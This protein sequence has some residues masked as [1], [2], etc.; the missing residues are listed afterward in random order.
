MPTFKRLISLLHYRPVISIIISNLV[1][2][3]SVFEITE[4]VIFGRNLPFYEVRK[5]SF[6]RG[7]IEKIKITIVF[8]QKI[9]ILYTDSIFTK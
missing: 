3:D 9:V 7:G 2:M 5:N 4:F 1:K 6:P 8:R